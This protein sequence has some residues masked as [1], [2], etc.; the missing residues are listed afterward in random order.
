MEPDTPGLEPMVGVKTLSR[1][2]DV[3]ES[4]WYAQAESQKIPSYRVG[5]Y[6]KFRVSEVESWMASRRQG[7]A[8]K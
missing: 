3:P 8:A 4:W 1:M 6:R 5:K 2:Y 7:P